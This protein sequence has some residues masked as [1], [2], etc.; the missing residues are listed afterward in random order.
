MSSGSGD[1]EG[2]DRVPAR[3]AR[4]AATGDGPRGTAAG[5]RT[6]CTPCRGTGRVT[7]GLGGQPHEVTCP[8]C[9]G[10]G[11]FVPGRDAQEEPADRG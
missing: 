2:S 6:T 3:E 9:A 5:E 4:D 11:Q 7:S 8:W 1:Q 10:T